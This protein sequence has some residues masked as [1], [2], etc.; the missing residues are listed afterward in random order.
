MAKQVDI[1]KISGIFTGI[2]EKFSHLRSG[3]ITEHSQVEMMLEFP[4]QDRLSFAVPLYLTDDILNFTARRLWAEYFPCT[5]Q[6]VIDNYAEDVV[7]LLSGEY[8]IIEFLR[9]DK[10]VKSYLEKPTDKGWSRAY[11]HS[12][13]GIFRPWG[14]T[15]RLVQNNPA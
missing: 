12:T 4:E 6:K 15:R 13:L 2:R 8:R 9:G 5:E 7:G 10:V 1:E 3:L 14:M 11:S